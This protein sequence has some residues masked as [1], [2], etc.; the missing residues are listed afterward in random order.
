MTEEE[1]REQTNQRWK[2]T[3]ALLGLPPATEP[4]AAA[5]Q[6]PATPEPVAERHVAEP[7]PART[8]QEPEPPH[9]WQPEPEPEAVGWHRRE[10]EPP[11][12][13]PE[14]SKES[15]PTGE[16]PPVE[17]PGDVDAFRE[18]SPTA[19]GESEDG[20]RSR[21]RRRGRRG[22]RGR[23]ERATESERPS[24]G[25]PAETDVETRS[26]PEAEPREERP[27]RRGGRGRSQRGRRDEENETR[28]VR[29][30]ED[31]ESEIISEEPAPQGPEE[32]PD[33]LSDWNVPSWQELISSLYR[34]DR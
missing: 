1:I 29:E 34:P 2:E 18:P 31:Q 8:W 6:P 32:E 14:R 11:D 27:P 26:E 30:E 33:M 4:P 25:T 7:E 3:L 22:G 28:E 13:A 5:H 23:S 9:R 19:G 21:G 15:E 24:S 20:P 16:V 12:S 17:G 10:Q